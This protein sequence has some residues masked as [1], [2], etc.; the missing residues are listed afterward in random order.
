[1]HLPL[2]WIILSV[3]AA[4]AIGIDPSLEARF[5]SIL[6]GAKCCVELLSFDIEY[7]VLL[8]FSEPMYA[9]CLRLDAFVDPREIREPSSFGGTESHLRPPARFFLAP[10]GFLSYAI[11]HARV[12]PGADLLALVAS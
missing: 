2:P 3:V 8:R 6:G 11:S 10:K 7:A 12:I 4:S 9:C 5:S 1:M